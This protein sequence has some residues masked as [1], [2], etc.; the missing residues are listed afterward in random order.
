MLRTTGPIAKAAI[1]E[2][3][4]QKSKV[5][6]TR[7]R[8]DIILHTPREVSGGAKLGNICFRALKRKASRSGALKDFDLMD[9][10]IATLDY[11]LGIFL[12]IGA[13]ETFMS[14]YSGQFPQNILGVALTTT[15]EG[16][17]V[18]WGQPS[19]HDSKT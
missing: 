8:P 10:L 19:R 16:P 6:G 11:Q 5:H 12:N 13:E 7:Q 9:E 15:D 17:V 2:M 3:E 4:Y 18:V 1:L 14:E